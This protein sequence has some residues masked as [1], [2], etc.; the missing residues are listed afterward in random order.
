MSY[1]YNLKILFFIKWV[2]EYKKEY[3]YGKINI[4]NYLF[5]IYDIIKIKYK[6]H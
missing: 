2:F 6:K 4:N 5:Q 1:N 3:I